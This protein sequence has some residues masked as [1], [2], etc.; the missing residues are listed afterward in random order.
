MSGTQL[1]A[2]KGPTARRK[3]EFLLMPMVGRTLHLFFSY[4]VP[5]M[6]HGLG[7]LTWL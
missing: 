2:V 3:G 6:Q 4:V 7:V 1:I 5:L